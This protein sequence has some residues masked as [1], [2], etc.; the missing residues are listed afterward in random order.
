MYVT[1]F[2]IKTCHFFVRFKKRLLETF[3]MSAVRDF[4]FNLDSIPDEQRALQTSHQENEAE[5]EEK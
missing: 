2:S 1:L 3:K 4:R 5:E